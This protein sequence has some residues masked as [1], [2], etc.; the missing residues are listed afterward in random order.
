MN[1]ENCNGEGIIMAG[2]QFNISEPECKD[3]KGTGI[4]QEQTE[5][6]KIREE[7]GFNKGYKKAQ[8]DAQKDI[9]ELKKKIAELQL[10]VDYMPRMC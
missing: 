8:Q 9:E 1:C 5:D 4:Q 2:D 7:I 3:C 6:E 10:L